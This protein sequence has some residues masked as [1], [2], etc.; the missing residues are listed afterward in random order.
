[1]DTAFARMR[2][3]PTVLPDAP[4][5]PNAP[6]GSG[7]LDGTLIA[8]VSGWRR[9]ENLRPGDRVMT[10]D[11]GPVRLLARVELS[12]PSRRASPAHWPRLV[13]PGVLGNR[14]PLRLCP[15][16]GVLVE[17]AAAEA[18]T[19]EPFALVE[20]CAL[21]GVGG[22]APV[23][24]PAAARIWRLEFAEDQVVLAEGDALIHCRA[25]TS[26]R[27]IQRYRPLEAR[28]VAGLRM[29]LSAGQRLRYA[30]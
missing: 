25:P 24:Q 14:A 2:T 9:V 22:I 1:M 15:G 19:G 10:L 20:L 6:D 30:Q 27:G 8:T 23:P 11:S 16:Q 12:G 21:D 28:A 26:A 4:A 18:I 29:F 13:P 5:S 3:A 17:G 7:V